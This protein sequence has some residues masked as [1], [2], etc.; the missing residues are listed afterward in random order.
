MRPETPLAGQPDRD[1]W[2]YRK[3]RR[4]L[5]ACGLK[6]RSNPIDVAT[7]R[8]KHISVY[9]RDLQPQAQK[10][11][12]QGANSLFLAVHRR[13]HCPMSTIRAGSLDS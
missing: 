4:N 6:R 7:K 3:G 2:R 8:A 5:G 10:P 9:A 1:V 11:G 13:Q 12:N